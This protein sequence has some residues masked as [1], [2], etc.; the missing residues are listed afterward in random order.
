MTWLKRLWRRIIVLV[1]RAPT[2][3][4]SAQEAPTDSQPLWATPTLE[5][6]RARPNRQT[7]RALEAA[8][9]KHD[10]FIKPKE[11][12]IIPA[13]M[14]APTRSER[15]ATKPIIEVAANDD[16]NDYYIADDWLEG[17]GD[18]VL[19]ERSEMYGEFNFRDTILD[20]LDRY[21]YYLERMKKKD[22]DAYEFYKRVGATLIPYIGSGTWRKA[23]K[24][25]KYSPQ[26]AAKYRDEIKLSPWFKQHLPMFGCCA[27]GTNP[28]DEA[29][30]MTWNAEKRGKLWVPKF[31]YFIK[32][33]NVPWMVQPVHGGA[34]Y[35]IVVWWDKPQDPE[36][37]RKWGTPQSFHVHILGD[38]I[39]ALKTRKREQRPYF[40]R[41]SHWYG[42]SPDEVGPSWDWHYPADYEE[43][44]KCY[45][46]TARDHLAHTFINLIEDWEY[47]TYSMTR[48]EVTKGDL[49]AV[50]GVNP[51]R[52]AYFFQDRDIVYTERGIKKRIFHLVRP[53]VRKDGTSVPMHFRGARKFK[54]AGYNVSITIPGRDHEMLGEID[55]AL[56]HD[57]V[58]RAFDTKDLAPMGEMGKWIKEK[59]IKGGLG[60]RR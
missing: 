38:T 40:K 4:V 22:K 42:W 53:H 13:R 1:F 52:L 54:W 31:L 27:I 14:P 41:S 46:L 10:K 51:K 15:K 45:G 39:T 24:F 26:E 32:L 57:P 49:T 19:F 18:K 56:V 58:K 47:S 36:Y 60:A 55:T 43:W 3:Q 11:P 25:K 7:R 8:R 20:Q 33:K 12:E 17:S 5:E 59:V 23:G 50:F 21:W 28:V 48:V 37:K 34:I 6:G 16:P 44:A 2:P 9:R 30:E 35:E 29:K